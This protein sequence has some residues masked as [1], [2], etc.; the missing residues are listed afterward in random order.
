M[1]DA[2]VVGGTGL[3]STGIVKHLLARGARVTMYNRGQRARTVPESVHQIVGNRDDTA[4]FV[5]TFADRRFDVVYDMICFSPEQAEASVRAFGGRCA[6]FVFCSTVCTYRVH[7]PP[8]VLID[9]SWPLEPPSEYGRNK[10]RCEQL[11]QQAAEG[12]AFE[13]TI[14]RPSHTY[15][16]GNSLIDQQEFDSGTWD[17]VARGLPVLL[18]GDGLGLWQST[19]RDDCGRFFAHAALA[20]STFGQAYNVTRDEVLTW[21]AYYREVARALDT[22]AKLICVPA[23]WLIAQAPERFKFLAETTRFHGAYSS[24]KA[25][26]HVPEFRAEVG[27]E[28]GARETFADMHRRGAWRDSRADSTYQGLVERALALGFEIE[29]A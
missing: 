27:L 1:L 24:A 29:P 16:P 5:A 11:L 18:A 15:G 13:L 2:L 12:G 14:A 7:S 8:G 17:R 20:P 21:R 19:H 22:E 3:I 25:K 23:G 26:A 28:A 6:Q 4:A 10:V 9:E